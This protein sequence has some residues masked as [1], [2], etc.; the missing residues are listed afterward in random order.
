[1]DR[2]GEQELTVGRERYYKSEEDLKG[3]KKPM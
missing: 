2:F 3:M 1:M